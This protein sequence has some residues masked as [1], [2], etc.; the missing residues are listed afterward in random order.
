MGSACSVRVGGRLVVERLVFM[1]SDGLIA[2]R[3]RLVELREALLAEQERAAEDE[4]PVELDQARMGRLSR[5][6]SMQQQAMALELGRRRGLQLKRI[7]G[8]LLRVDKGT[9]GVCVTCGE[10]LGAERLDFDPTV[11]FCLGC[12]QR[13]ERQG[14]T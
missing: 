9:Y 7:E 1:D 2:T 11:F 14:R 3:A 12:S 6:D 4:A 13:V 10:V 5:M 8:A